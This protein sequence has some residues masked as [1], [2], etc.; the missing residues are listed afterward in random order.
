M[1]INIHNLR[2][3][4]RPTF[5]QHNSTEDMDG[6]ML[7]G[8]RAHGNPYLGRVTRIIHTSGNIAGPDTYANVLKKRTGETPVGNRPPVWEETEIRCVLAKISDPSVRVVPIVNRTTQKCE[9]F[10]DG[11]PAS[12]E[13]AAKIQGWMKPK[14]AGSNPTGFATI[15]LDAMVNVEE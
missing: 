1:A 9:L 14:K 2:P 3:G 10:L 13:D 11:A 6:K 12:P 7:L 15:G 8:G 4:M 5:I